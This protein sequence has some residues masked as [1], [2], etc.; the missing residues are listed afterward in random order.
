MQPFG[1]SLVTL[2]LT[3]AQIDRVLEQQ[4]DGQGTSPKVLQ[5]SDG[6]TYTWDP[7]ARSGSRVDR[8]S[9]KIGGVTVDPAASYRVTVNSFLADGGDGFT[10]LRDGTD[11]LGGD[12]DLDALRRVPRPRHNPIAPTARDR[13]TVGPVGVLSAGGR[14]QSTQCP[15][16]LPCRRRRSCAARSAAGCA[17]CAATCGGSSRPPWRPGRRGSSPTCCIRSRSSPRPRRSSRWACRAAGA[18]CGRSSWWSASPSASWSR[19]SSCER[20]ARTRSS[21]CSSSDSRWPRRCCFGAGQILVNQ[22]AIS[23]ILVVATLQPGSS[24]S[25]ARVRRRPHRRGGGAARRPGPVPARPGPGDGEGGAAGGQRPGGGAQGARRG[26]ARGRRAARPARAGDRPRHRRRPR[27]LLR[28]GG[29]GARDV[30]AARPRGRS[31][32]AFRSTPR[33]PSRWTTPCATRACSPAAR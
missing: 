15:P 8:A 7:A 32:S 28:R 12:I 22:A 11:R 19:T 20:S 33:P 25:P 24:P 17:A 30:R 5:V 27:R 14:A 13:I 16:A 1:N 3:G 31:A 9:I 18:R 2:T 4:W 29:A 6:L 26:A 10:E 21:S 23:G